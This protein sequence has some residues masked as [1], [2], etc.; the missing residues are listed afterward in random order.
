M[1]TWIVLAI[2]GLFGS[3]SAEAG[4]APASGESLFTGQV[5]AILANSCVRCHG[6]DHKKGELD[7]SRRAPALKGGENGPAIVPGNLDE[8]LLIEKVAAGEMPPKSPLKPEQVEALRAWV[9]A[10]APYPREPVSPPRAGADWWSLRPIKDASPPA[11]DAEATRWVRTPVDAFILAKLRENK[12]T[13]APEADRSAL[14]RRLSF[15]LIG[16]PPSPE[17]VARFVA[18]A[19]PL[20]YE[21]LVDRLLASPQY[22]E[23]W[24]R[25]WLDVVRFGESEGY[26]TNMPRFNA[27]PYRDY[28]IRAFNRDTPFPQFVVE[29]LAADVASGGA[30]KDWL[31]QAAT[32]FLVGGTHDIVGN[33]TIEGM[34]QQRVDDLDDVVTAT[35]TA[36]LGLTINCARCHDHKFDPILQKDYYGFQAVFAG[37]NHAS[38]AVEAAD[39][40]ARREKATSVAAELAR[41]DQGLDEFEP[42]ARLDADSPARPM[43]N[44][45]RNVERFAPI[46][47]R[48]VRMTILATADPIEPCI[49]EFEVYTAES[50]PRNV[51]LASAGGKA[52]AS[53]EYPGSAIHK[54]EHLNDGKLGNGRSWI[55]HAPGKGVVTI[56]WPE[57]ALIDRVVWGRDREEAYRDRLAS[58]YVIE[59][60][61]EP[62]AWRVVASSLDRAAYKAD[63]PPAAAADSGLT[64]EAAARRAELQ[65]RRAELKAKLDQLGPTVSMYVG[66]FT[67]PAT[68]HLLRRGDPMQPGAQVSPSAVAAVEPALNLSPDAPEGERRLALARWI[69]DPANPLPARVM[70][71]R[72]WHYHFGRG[73][74]ATPSD[75]GFNGAAP[76]HP[77]LL[78]W[79]AA[80]Y[81]AGGWRLKPLHRL[82]VLSAAYRQSSRGDA[83]AQ[84]VDRENR[85]VWRM[86]PRRLEAEAVRDS[87]LA[88]AGKLDPEMGGPG[89]N[90][91]EKN[92][93]Y[94]AIYKP[95]GELGP[96]AFRRMIYQFKPRSQQDPT[97]GSFDCP[98]AALVAPRRNISTTALQALDL[99]NSGFIIQQSGLFAQR[100]ADE[101]GADPERQVDRGFALA[102]G[103]PPAPAERAA[104]AALIR[105][106]GTPSFCRAL[107]NANEFVY[108]P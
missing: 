55:S 85:L 102:L 86:S 100:L 24:G 94:V 89:Y 17:E 23:R 71:N 62:G 26:E 88:V 61:D 108:A 15:D 101:V 51:A 33:A 93:N 79:L 69:G 98:D 30:S 99:L 72:V 5:E 66:T 75:F 1:R 67:Q 60:A 18:D 73:I 63:A 52:T 35:G 41:V 90:I 3:S 81:I 11:L 95:R 56:A 4:E 28:V 10:G 42:V 105:A 59:A 58:Q 38:R 19:D 96:D 64:S 7:L 91:W 14:I 80:R 92:T 87:I 32:G 45:R 49:D 43:V 74:V 97:F 53:S 83:G 103:R 57:P 47:A 107:Y 104:A 16:L 48:M 25:H 2:V 6:G 40:E 54:I 12:L 77:E 20:A 82:I 68:T 27:W 21:T 46:K 31:S 34:R 22:G 9:K 65:K 44:P 13:P 78:D 37:V 36:F 8:S 76:S 106:R 50:S 39:A 84:A 70:V 29:Q